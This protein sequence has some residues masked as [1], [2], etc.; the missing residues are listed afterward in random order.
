MAR[1]SARGIP[2]PV[3]C[4]QN[5]SPLPLAGRAGGLGIARE[6]PVA[7]PG[8]VPKSQKVRVVV[9]LQ[10]GD[11]MANQ[12][13]ATGHS[14]LAEGIRGRVFPDYTAFPQL[15]MASDPQR[16]I[17]VLRERLKPVA[18]RCLRI[19]SCE[20]VRF[21]FSRNGSRCLLQHALRLHDLETRQQ[22]STWICLVLYADPAEGERKWLELCSGVSIQSVPKNHATFQPLTFL[23][24]FQMLIWVYPY[25]PF[26]RNLPS[27]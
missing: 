13:N 12:A 26:L 27:I 3:H 11:Q 25:D 10:G 9:E 6:K 14:T 23:C 5:V 1:G 17:G 19:E 16:L 22:L 4:R 18:G 2:T 15:K 21:R 20:P 7:L 8:F 24:E